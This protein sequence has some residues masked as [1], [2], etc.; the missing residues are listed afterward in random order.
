MRFST[1][2]LIV[3]LIVSLLWLAQSVFAFIAKFPQAHDVGKYGYMIAS[4]PFMIRSKWDSF[5][6]KHASL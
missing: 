4:G 1:V 3:I 5:L 6:R 2:I